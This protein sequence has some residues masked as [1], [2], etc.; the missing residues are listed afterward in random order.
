MPRRA[1]YALELYPNADQ[2]LHISCQGVIVSNGI[3]VNSGP[4]SYRVDSSNTL[5]C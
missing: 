2:H 5:G 3:L 4:L 1:E